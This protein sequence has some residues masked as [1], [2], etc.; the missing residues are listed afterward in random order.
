MLYAA[1]AA[2]S[3]DDRYAKT[4]AGTWGLF[5]QSFVEPGR[6]DGELF[7]RA[8]KT[9]PVREGADYDARIVPPE[10]AEAI[11]ALAERFVAAVAE[12]FP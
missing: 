9:Q 4:H 1:R 2:L 10:Q 7:E 6:F 11:V 5:R 12:V 3:E 8:H